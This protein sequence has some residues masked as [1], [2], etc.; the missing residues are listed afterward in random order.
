MQVTHINVSSYPNSKKQRLYKS[1][2]GIGR[3]VKGCFFYRRN[4]STSLVCFATCVRSS[5]FNLP[6]CFSE[7][8]FLL[9]KKVKPTE[10]NGRLETE[11]HLANSNLY[12]LPLLSCNITNSVYTHSATPKPPRLLLP[13]RIQSKQWT[14]L[15]WKRTDKLQQL[16]RACLGYYC[17]SINKTICT[18]PPHSLQSNK[19]L[20]SFVKW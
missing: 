8:T 16:Y 7:S 15:F 20:F 10:E 11:L 13:G 19:K 17:V 12:E 9:T 6:G 1:P 18:P 5:W 4:Q 14:M 2:Y 3:R